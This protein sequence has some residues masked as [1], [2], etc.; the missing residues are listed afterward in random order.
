MK[1]E[2][3]HSRHQGS[4]A[5][6]RRGALWLA[7]VL[8]AAA[9]SG[10]SPIVLDETLGMICFPPAAMMSP[11]CPV[12]VGIDPA[13]VA[14]DPSGE[15]R[16]R[17]RENDKA[18]LTIKL[19]GMSPHQVATAWFVH[20]PP[21]QPPPHPIFAP[22]GPGQPPV[23]H[24]D[25]PVAPTG[26]AFSE[27]LG[28][29]PNQFRILPNGKARLAVSLD[30]NPLKSQ[31]VPLVNG[32]VLTNQGPAPAGSVAE[33]PSCCMDFPAG[34]Q[35][36]AVGGSYLRQ[37]DPVTG[38]Q[39][40]G[41]DGRPELVRSPS[42]PVAVAII[43]HIDSVTSGIVPGVPTPPFLVDPPVTTGSFYLLGIFPLGPLGMD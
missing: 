41:P 40:L 28:G 21:G 31:Q 26:A 7:L 24:M 43:I 4:R 27:G 8:S 5:A 16:V 36:E 29:E 12:P 15:L 1:N 2:N 22:I 13:I 33:Q 42:R 32:M 30:Y 17:V 9:S 10:A 20:F 14:P 18:R 3:P 11:P 25:S 6:R 35:L 37:F 34:P 19:N 23:A 39:S 38:F